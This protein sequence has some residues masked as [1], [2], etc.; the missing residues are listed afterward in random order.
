LPGWLPAFEVPLLIG[1]I[2]DQAR[3]LSPESRQQLERKLA[4]FERETSNQVVVLTIESLQGDN[5]DQFS[6]RVAES[7]K[8]GQQGRDN[9]VLLVLAKEERKV[10][11]EVGLGLQGVL[12]D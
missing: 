1:R 4:A 7:W 12:P 9:G 2:N 5:I 3:M 6:I 11:I 8:I 10:R